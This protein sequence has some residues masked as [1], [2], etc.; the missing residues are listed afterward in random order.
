MTTA[1]SSNWF[2]RGV[3]TAKIALLRT[4]RPPRPAFESPVIPGQKG[5]WMSICVVTILTLICFVWA[6]AVF[7]EFQ[8]ARAADRGFE[9][10]FYRKVTRLG[11]SKW[12]IGLTAVFG[13]VLSTVKWEALKRKQR[14]FWIS[15]YSDMNFLFFTSVFSGVLAYLLKNIIGRARPKHFMELGPNYFEMFSFERTMAS[16]PSGHSTTF[17]ATCMA[18]VLFFPRLWWLWLMVAIVGGVTRIMMLSHYPS[19]AI[20]GLVFGAVFT[21]LSA[22]WL[23][24]KGVM[25]RFND[26]VLPQRI[27]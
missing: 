3:N 15:V 19:D 5:F 17:G 24:R 21:L 27:R 9:I 25:F 13:L 22:R 11:E 7:Y 6:D 4:L 12:V 1:S 18:L 2:D 16:F 23:A 26:G 14:L 10:N 8:D 20:A